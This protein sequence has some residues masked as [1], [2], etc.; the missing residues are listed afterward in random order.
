MKTH[1][2]NNKKLEIEKAQ[3]MK[4]ISS[5]NQDGIQKR[6]SFSFIFLLLGLEPHGLFRMFFNYR[7][8]PLLHYRGLLLEILG[9]QALRPQDNR[10]RIS[11]R[12]TNRDIKSKISTHNNHRFRNRTSQSRRPRYK[13]TNST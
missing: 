5:H 13:R 7:G 2:S 8:P 12:G 6:L 4:L 10:R 3:H 11:Y 1:R 9:N